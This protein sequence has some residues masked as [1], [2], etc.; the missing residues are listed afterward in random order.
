VLI[1]D[2]TGIRDC[3]VR[4]TWKTVNNM[5]GP[6][7]AFLSDFDMGAWPSSD[8]ADVVHSKSAQ[9]GRKSLCQRAPEG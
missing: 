5:E 1:E 7:A 8:H 4:R 2:Q 6:C 3:S 9:V